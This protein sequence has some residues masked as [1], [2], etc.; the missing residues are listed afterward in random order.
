MTTSIPRSRRLGALLAAGA[1]TAAA[2]GC[3]QS[4]REGGSGSGSGS[5]EEKTFV[6]SGAA[7]PT[8]LDPFYASDGETFRIARQQFEGLVG[9]KPGTADPAPLLATSWETS[10][11]GLSHTLELRKGVKFSDG[12]PF[13]A[14]AVCWNF[15]RWYNTP[16][17]L[18]QGEDLTYYYQSLFKGFATG[19]LSE[20]AIYESCKADGDSSVTIN[21]TEPWSGFIPALSL[22][23]F[24]MQSPTALQKYPEPKNGDPRKGPY[25]TAHPTGTGPFVLDS[26]ERGKQVTLKANP[27]YWGEKPKVD[28]VVIVAIDDP[29]A[30]AQALQNGDIDGYDLVGPG[31]IESLKSEGFQIVDRA[32][33]NIL[34]LGMNQK[35]GALDDIR[36]RQAIAHAIDKE[37]VASQ[38]MPEGTVVASQFVPDLVNGYNPDVPTY[39]YDPGKAKQLLKAAGQEDMTLQFNYPTDVSRPYMPAPGDTFKAI[40]SQL[41]KVGITIKPEADTWSPDYLE[42]VQGTADHGIHLLGWTGDYNDTD[43]F[44]GVFFG[45]KSNEWGFDNPELFKDLQK[46]RVIPTPEEAKPMYE[47]INAEVMEFL[48]GIPLAHP[49]PSLAFA[50]YVSG[51]QASPV[52]DEVWNTVDITE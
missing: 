29:T 34:Y 12:T 22:P 39:D 43:N 15:D 36:V 14:D 18:T 49:V 16:E 20:S 2:A 13:N 8:T 41:E 38:T 50:D 33:F 5:D 17:G 9:T 31:D 4:E 51:Y 21:L 19:P 45:Q 24:S 42:K 28:R 23:A 25:A 3:A 7:E 11:D 6:F 37:A 30:R 10:D 47:Q 26:W 40:S 1:L 35:Y 27:D 44:L 32:P 52:Q 48:P 46:A